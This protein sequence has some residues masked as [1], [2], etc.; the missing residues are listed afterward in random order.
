MGTEDLRTADVCRASGATYLQG[1]G[2]GSLVREA[3]AYG[4]GWYLL[5]VDGS[6]PIVT[7]E[8][9]R[10]IDE[11]MA[12]SVVTLVCLDTIRRHV[13]TA[14][15]PAVASTPSAN[16]P[17]P[18]RANP[19]GGVDGAAEPSLTTTN[20]ERPGAVNAEPLTTAR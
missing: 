6:Q 8:P 1:K 9:S 12:C 18:A 2:V 20:D 10:A 5:L 17:D 15:R 7:S 11:A 16:R 19:A 14:L 13:T 3:F 4:P